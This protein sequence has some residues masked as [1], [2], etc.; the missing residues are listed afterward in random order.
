LFW[1][2]GFLYFAGDSIP[3]QDPPPAVEEAYERRMELAD[4]VLMIGMVATLAGGI[5]GAVTRR[6]DNDK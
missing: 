3:P 6:R 4:R 5:V 2:C 1:V